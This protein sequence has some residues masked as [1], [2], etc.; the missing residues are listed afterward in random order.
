MPGRGGGESPPILPRQLWGQGISALLPGPW[1]GSTGMSTK[2]CGLPISMLNI[3]AYL[4]PFHALVAV[5]ALVVVVVAASQRC[6]HR[7]LLPADSP[8]LRRAA[9]SAASMRE[10]VSADSH[11]LHHHAWRDLP[12]PPPCAV[13]CGACGRGLDAH[14]PRDRGRPAGAPSSSRRPR[15]RRAGSSGLQA[16][17][18][19]WGEA[20]GGGRVFRARASRAWAWHCHAGLALVRALTLSLVLL[21]SPPRAALRA[22]GRGVDPMAAVT[23]LV[24]LATG[25]PRLRSCEICGL[26][27]HRGEPGAAPSPPLPFPP[28]FSRSFLPLLHFL[29]PS[30]LYSPF[31]FSSPLSSPPDVPFHLNLPVSPPP[32]PTLSPP[33]PFSL[34]WGPRRRGSV[35]T[36]RVPAPCGRGGW[37]P[38]ASSG[39]QRLGGCG[40]GRSGGP[41]GSTVVAV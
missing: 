27:A 20:T 31:P 37:A 19:R 24:R 28:P 4:N 11:P 25:R 26:V 8:T 1:L 2:C 17:F 22:I 35:G 6:R 41:V 15:H 23:L 9:A 13:A 40:D 39:L 33:P 10:M 36:A 7:P 3:V 38:L 5:F 30:T 16:A 18:R 29:P 14:P 21:S 12:A 32:S 34:R